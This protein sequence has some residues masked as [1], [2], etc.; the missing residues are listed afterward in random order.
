[1]KSINDQVIQNRLIEDELEVELINWNTSGKLGFSI[2]GG[3]GSQHIRGD[4]GIYIKSIQDNGLVSW[5]G[6]IWVGDRLVAVKQGLDGERIDL[7]NRTHENAVSILRKVCSGKRTVLIVKKTEINLINWSKNDHLG[8]SIAG[9]VDREHIPG[10]SRIYI[11][12]IVDGG[13]VARDGRVA[14]GDRLLGVKQKIKSNGMRSED[15]FLM[16]KCT[17]DSAVNALENSRKGKHVILI[18]SKENADHPRLRFDDPPEENNIRMEATQFYPIAFGQ[19]LLPRSS[20][21]SHPL[22]KEKP[23]VQMTKPILKRRESPRSVRI[24]NVDE[25]LGDVTA[26]NPARIRYMSGV[27]IHENDIEVM[28]TDSTDEPKIVECYNKDQS[29]NSNS[30][31]TKESLNTST[32]SNSSTASTYEHDSALSSMS[33]EDESQFLDF[34]D[35]TKVLPSININSTTTRYFKTSPKSRHCRTNS[36]HVIEPLILKSEAPV[37]HFSRSPPNENAKPNIYNHALTTTS[38]KNTVARN[39]HTETFTPFNHIFKTTRKFPGTTDMPKDNI[40]TMPDEIEHIQSNLL[41]YFNRRYNISSRNEDITKNLF[42]GDIMQE[43]AEPSFNHINTK[44]LM[45]TTAH[46]VL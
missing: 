26:K 36:Q 14:V 22:S 13:S 44:H 19:D 40:T 34:S 2:A 21:L 35:I 38:I 23:N 9:G 41:D 7:N 8:F 4:N 16:E 18:I 37:S 45:K 42:N 28:S 3:V 12:R 46:Y 25:G 15:F 30:P 17:H 31:A 32:N 6:R 1:M 20:L 24:E 29:Y 27:P 43:D 11:T 39:V 5:D 10:D 33:S